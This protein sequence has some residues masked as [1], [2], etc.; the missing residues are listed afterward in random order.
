M[1]HVYC[2]SGLGADERIF[3]KLQVPDAEFHFI[4]WEQPGPGESISSY[5]KKLC[6][7]I[8]H[9]QPILM[10][11]SFGGMMAIEMAKVSLVEKV[12]LISSIKS[13]NELP[14]WMKICGRF[15]FDK[16]LPSKPLHTIRPLK[17]LRPVQNYFLGTE[18]AEEKAIANQFRDTVDPHYLRWS[19]NQ[20]LNWQNNW[21]PQT[22]FHLHGA[23]DHIF[24][25][26]HVKPT[27]IIPN[28]GHFMIMNKCKEIS[29][30]LKE[31][32]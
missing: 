1:H 25:L 12:V 11:V 26:K 28:A 24:P 27:H 31:I 16:I 7:Q 15:R 13:L 19:I 17:A 3:C 23:N 22:I 9:D 21:Q 32:L 8:Q 20:V 30:I 29:E 6:N 2:I 14:R 4:R 10:G 5:A 18:S